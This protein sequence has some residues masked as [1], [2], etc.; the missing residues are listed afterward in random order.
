[1]ANRISGNAT[2]DTRL[3]EF[4]KIGGILLLITL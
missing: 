2:H 1:M 3:D 4:A